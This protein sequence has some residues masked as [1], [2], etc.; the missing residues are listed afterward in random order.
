VECVY[1]DVGYVCVYEYRES[2]Y[3]DVCVQKQPVMAR[4]SHET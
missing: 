4:R 3:V 2:V 1:V